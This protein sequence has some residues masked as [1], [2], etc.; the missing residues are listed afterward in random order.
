MGAPQL[1]ARNASRVTLGAAAKSPN[2]YPAI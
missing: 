1:D 2:A